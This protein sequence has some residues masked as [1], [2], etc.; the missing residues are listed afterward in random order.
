MAANKYLGL[1]AGAKKLI[2]ALQTSAGVADAGKIIATNDQG[3]LDES[4]LPTGIGANTVPLPATEALAAGSF[5]NVFANAGVASVRLADNTNGRYADG[6]VKDAVANAATATVYPLDT[7]NS[8]V[9]GLTA[10]LRY[11]LGTA[12]GTIATPL[13]ET[14]AGNVGKISQYLGYAK[15]PTELVTNDDSYVVL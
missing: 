2:A 11:Y 14:A 9:T 3:K 12:G 13:D 5:V 15:S 1:V 6:Y 7:T 8:S 4:L 10:G